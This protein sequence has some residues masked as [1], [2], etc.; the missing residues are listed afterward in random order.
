MKQHFITAYAHYSNGSIEIINREIISLFRA[1]ISELRWDKHHWP[2]LV[3]LVEHTLNHRPQRR[4]GGHAPI[5][6]MSGLQ[7]D[8]PLDAVFY[9][10]LTFTISGIELESDTISRHV[11]LLV[12][13]LS[14]MHKTI[15]ELTTDE[16]EKRRSR[17]S[18]NR[19][20]P[21]FGIGDYV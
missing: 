21:N 15:G 10:P 4:L 6:V 16:R 14:C 13:S 5:T 12:N 1:L 17:C 19:S 18:N 20:L 7:P 11:E 3:K 8:N 9:N 2:C